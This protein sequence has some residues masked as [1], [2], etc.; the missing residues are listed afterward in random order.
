MK[1]ETLVS[2][3][4]IEN[5]EEFVKLLKKMNIKRNNCLIINQ[6]TD[7]NL[8]LLNIKNGEKRIISLCEKGLSKSRNMAI[9]NSQGDIGI[10][11]DDDVIYVDNYEKIVEDEY[12]KNPGYDIIAFYVENA[13]EKD[14]L[15]E[16]NVDFIHSLKLCSV[17]ITLKINSIRKNNIVF[18]EKFGT[19]S[20]LFNFGEENIF[21]TDCLK[22]KMKIYY[23][24][25]KIAVLS[26]ERK[27][28]WFNGFDKAYFYT[29]GAI[30]YRISK[31]LYPLLI[32]QFIIRKR[33][34][35]SDTISMNEALKNMFKGVKKY[36]EVRKNEKK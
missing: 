17:Q 19:G 9:A 34:I 6:M 32:I 15:K 24:K 21:L 18:D 12:E 8:E 2:T 13:K 3:M 26:S 31:L 16:K 11:A 10:I 25:K 1:I 36:K 28:S 35:Y 23:S 29:R 30:F 7:K 27:S 14:N 4:N 22:K 5:K 33:K 20:G